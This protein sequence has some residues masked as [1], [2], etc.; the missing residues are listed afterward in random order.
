MS[1]YLELK[2]PVSWNAE[3]FAQLRQRMAEENISVRWQKRYYHI[4]A[5]F[6]YNDEPVEELT[7]V[8]DATLTRRKA[9]KLTLDTLD[10]FC[11]KEA[12]VII[13]NL[14][15]SH[16]SPDFNILVNQLREMAREQGANIDGNFLLHIT[17]G[18][19]DIAQTSIGQVRGIVSGIEVPSFT[20]QLKEAEYRYYRGGSIRCWTLE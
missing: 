11:A 9:P 3:W 5:A 12:P 8:F 19:I 6:I 17:L 10:A 2:V 14:T 20:L 15:S 4:T 18:R 1:N 16:L 7:K 13:V